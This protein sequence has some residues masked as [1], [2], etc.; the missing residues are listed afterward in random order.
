M[1][2]VIS[3]LFIGFILSIIFIIGFSLDDMERTESERLSSREILRQ[4]SFK[5]DLEVDSVLVFPHF[6]DTGALRLG[7][8]RFNSLGVSIDSMLSVMPK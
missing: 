2:K 1:Y 3:V 5:L 7:K 6:S 8:K 4:Y